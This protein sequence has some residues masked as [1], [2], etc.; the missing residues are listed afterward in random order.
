[1]YVWLVGWLVGW[2]DASLKFKNVRQKYEK[3]YQKKNT[4]KRNK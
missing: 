3:F 2:L 1:M 4:Q